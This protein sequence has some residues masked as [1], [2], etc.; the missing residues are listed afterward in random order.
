MSKILL[1]NIRG[2]DRHGLLAEWSKIMAKLDVKILDISQSIIHDS[3]N[4]SILVSIPQNDNKDHLKKELSKRAEERGLVAKFKTISKEHYFSWANEKESDR[5]I[6]TVLSKSMSARQL[7]LVTA[8]IHEQ[9]YNVENIRR[10]SVRNPEGREERY[11]FELGVRGHG[12]M[13]LQMKEKFLE[14]SNTEAID[15]AFQKDDI[16]RRNRRLVVFDMDSTLLKIEVIDELARKMGVVDQVSQI[17]EQAMNG[18]L[19]FDQS[20]RARVR[21]LKGMPHSVIQEIIDDLPLMEGA[22]KLIR[23]LKSLG[24]KVAILSGGFIN[25]VDE[26]KKRL[27]VDFGFANKLEF[28]DGIATG[29]VLGEIINGEKKL[30]YMKKIA[31]EE[32]LEMNQVIAIGDGANDLPMI[33]AAGLGIAFRAKPLVRASADH[34]LATLGLDGVL[35]LLG[36]RDSELEVFEALPS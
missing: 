3:L 24:Y 18:G 25:F 33:G 7:H 9:D 28:I 35:Y 16:Y 31:S 13:S 23:T 4:L 30:H 10:L 6:I 15:I 29:E 5:C 21:L 20:L 32:N 8:V 2:E 1:I 26:L 36:I 12:V 27:G 11:C 19:D 17:T 34:S 14:L 22:E